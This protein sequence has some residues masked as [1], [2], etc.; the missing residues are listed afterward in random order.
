ME[1]VCF[2]KA[3]SQPDNFNITRKGK[4][5]NIITTAYYSEPNTRTAQ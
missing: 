3:F 5:R 4:V 2:P 1:I